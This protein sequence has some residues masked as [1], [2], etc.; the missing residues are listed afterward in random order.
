ME[1]QALLACWS[2]G[3][4]RNAGYREFPVGSALVVRRNGGG[5]NVSTARTAKMALDASNPIES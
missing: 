3:K 2:T 4:S 5:D 1:I